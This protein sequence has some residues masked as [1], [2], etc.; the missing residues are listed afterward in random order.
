MKV[1]MTNRLEGLEMWFY[2]QIL[3]IISWIQRIAHV[4]VLNRIKQEED[5]FM[6]TIK[7]RKRE[8]LGYI[9]RGH[10]YFVLQLIFNGKL[11]GKRGIGR[12]KYS[13]LRSFRQW[14]GLLAEQYSAQDRRRYRQIVLETINA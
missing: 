9:L 2:R 3:I 12:K 4:E 11:E 7:R 8:H 1:D 6:N 13:W 10:R 5:E 14:T